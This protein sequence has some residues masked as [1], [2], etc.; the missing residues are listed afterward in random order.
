MKTNP[1]N[2]AFPATAPGGAS[3]SGLTIREY[4][5]AQIMQGMRASNAGRI[6]PRDGAHEETTYGVDW[7]AK[8]AVE[9]ADA[10][11]EALNAKE[12]VHA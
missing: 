3:Y 9:A 7:E 1:N 11:I 12:A 5:A 6:L 2:C 10:L 8:V 4:F